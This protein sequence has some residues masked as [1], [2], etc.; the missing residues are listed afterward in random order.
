MNLLTDWHAFC[1]FINPKGGRMMDQGGTTLLDYLIAVIV[2]IA[3]G[4]ALLHPGVSSCYL[5]PY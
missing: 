3:V 4:V 2:I 1:W 5:L